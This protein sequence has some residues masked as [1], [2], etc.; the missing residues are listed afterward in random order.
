MVSVI[1]W[2]ISSA[3]VLIYQRVPQHTG[4]RANNDDTYQRVPQHT[5][6]RANNDATYQRVP[7]HAGVRNKT[8]RRQNYKVSYLYS[9]VSFTN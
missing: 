7:Q 8:I 9:Q 4:V 1:F 5:G 2:S 3:E 6:V